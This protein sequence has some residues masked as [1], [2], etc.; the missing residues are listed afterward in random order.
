M[1]SGLAIHFH[2]EHLSDSITAGLHLAGRWARLRASVSI[3]HNTIHYTCAVIKKAEKK[4]RN[5]GGGKGAGME[6]R[7]EC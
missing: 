4:R 7:L 3:W 6:G 2:H 1:L 5:M